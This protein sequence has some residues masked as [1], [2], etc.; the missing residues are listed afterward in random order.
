MFLAPAIRAGFR[1]AR[2]STI[3]VSFGDKP[4]IHV[5]ATIGIAPGRR[6]EFLQEFHRL[7]PLVRAETGCIE[8]GPT[9]DVETGIEG[10]P[11]ARD[12]VVTVVE[13]W[14]TVASLRAHLAA[15]HMAKY[16]EAVKD[17]LTGVDIR[18]TEPV[19]G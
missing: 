16:R 8:Y 17:M 6:A 9:I 14:E 10:L 4:M 13:Q 7:V 5:I 1:R 15:P 11:A 18:V 2:F 19:S 12:N 3:V